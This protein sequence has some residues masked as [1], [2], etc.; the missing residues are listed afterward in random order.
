VTV[1]TTVTGVIQRLGEIDASLP[2]GDGV[3]VF[4][5]MYLGVTRRIGELLD[6]AG[7]PFA[8]GERMAELDVRFAGLWLHAYDAAAAGH[9]VP[10]AWAP[11]FESRGPG[12]RPVQYALS[13]MNTHIEHD[14]PLAV[15]RTCQSRGLQPETLRAD[16]SG[17]WRI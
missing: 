14:L 10:A 11:L 5:R 1:P 8:D 6:A 2:A 13:G 12:R 7:S 4:N 17:A 9:R 3:A 15:V 16:C